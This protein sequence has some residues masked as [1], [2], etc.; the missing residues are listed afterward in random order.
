M[1]I[2]HVLLLMST[3]KLSIAQLHF[4]YFFLGEKFP[5]YAAV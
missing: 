3:L 5:E 1:N 4:K 2:Q